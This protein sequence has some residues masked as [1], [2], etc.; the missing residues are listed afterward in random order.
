MIPLT[1]IAFLLAVATLESSTIYE[2]GIIYKDFGVFDGLGLGFVAVG[3][4]FF[5][6]FEEKPQKASIE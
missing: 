3:V 1:V 4:F 2:F 6:Y 5:N